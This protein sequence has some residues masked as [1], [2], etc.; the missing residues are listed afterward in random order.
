MTKGRIRQ[1]LEQFAT[2]QIAIGRGRAATQ[3]MSDRA[4][5][6]RYIIRRYPEF[7]DEQFR[8]APG[9][10]REREEEVATERARGILVSDVTDEDVNEEMLGRVLAL[11]ERLRVAWSDQDPRN[12]QWQAFVIRLLYHKT[13]GGQQLEAPAPTP[14]DQALEHFQANWQ[15]TRVC[16]RVDCPNAKYFFRGE[17][18]KRY[19]S[20]DCSLWATGDVRRRS[21]H[22]NKSKKKPQDAANKKAR[23][24][25]KR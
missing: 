15:K 11:G 14:F 10:R 25:A 7:F 9:I 12:K 21:Y 17:K 13:R 5:L 22:K 24:H 6:A 3:V 2:A 18:D 16:L 19:C 8:A 20:R 23:I 1:F 4:S